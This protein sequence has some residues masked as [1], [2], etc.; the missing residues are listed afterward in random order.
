MTHLFV[1]G[2]LVPGEDAWHLLEPWTTGLTRNDTARGRLYD[3]R[4]GYPAATFDPQAP[5]MVHG[6]VVELDTARVG[7]ALGALDAYEAEEYERVQIV[8]EG[9]IV[10]VTYA[11]VAPLDH[12]DLVAGGRWPRS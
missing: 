7:A 9:G 3:T 6:A 11:W 2:T 5:G 8:T 10:A 12:C 4:R 1:Y